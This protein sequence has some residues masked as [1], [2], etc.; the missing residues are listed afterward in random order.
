[1]VILKFSNTV[2][3]CGAQ[4]A[5]S[6]AVSK[7][8]LSGHGQG[9][10]WREKQWENERCRTINSLGREREGGREGGRERQS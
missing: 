2:L 9:C 7:V 6:S 3:E 10:S 8:G 4:S 5:F 1:M